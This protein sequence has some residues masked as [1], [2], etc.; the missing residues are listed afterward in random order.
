MGMAILEEPGQLAWLLNHPDGGGQVPGRL[1]G[2]RACCRCD[3]NP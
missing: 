2:D 3:N 1:A